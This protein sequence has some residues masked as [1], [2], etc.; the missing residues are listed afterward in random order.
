MAV[1]MKGAGSAGPA[2]SPPATG[3][4]TGQPV[5]Q[6]GGLVRVGAQDAIHA[7]PPGPLH[8]TGIVIDEDELGGRQSKLRG[9]IVEDAGVLFGLPQVVTVEDAIEEG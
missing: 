1:V 7:A 9:H 3:R 6:E 2:D 8:V 4:A 5:E